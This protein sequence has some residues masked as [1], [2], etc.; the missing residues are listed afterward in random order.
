VQK[1]SST[2]A[3]S[4]YKEKL[5]LVESLLLEILNEWPSQHHSE[6]GRVTSG[7]HLVIVQQEKHY[8]RV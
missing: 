5:R 4:L 8:H 2:L 6:E 3:M 1:W 7:V